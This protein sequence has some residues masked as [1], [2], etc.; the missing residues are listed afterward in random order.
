MRDTIDGIN[1]KAW[2]RAMLKQDTPSSRFMR[3]AKR[4]VN[5]HGGRPVATLEHGVIV[6]TYPDGTRT[7]GGARLK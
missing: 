5:T 7:S 6:F 2:E 1:E 4:V 3:T